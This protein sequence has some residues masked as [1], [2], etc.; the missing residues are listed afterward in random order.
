VITTFDRILSYLKL[1]TGILMIGIG[2]LLIL[3]CKHFKG[4]LSIWLLL[5]ICGFV[6]LFIGYK[7]FKHCNSHIDRKIENEKKQ[8]I[9]YLKEKGILKKL[10]FKD[11]VIGRRSE[12]IEVDAQPA[13][14]S[15]SMDELMGF[16]RSRKPICLEYSI[17]Y[18]KEIKDGET[19]S[20]ISPEIKK[21]HETLS[22]LVEKQQYINLYV[23]KEDVENY[24]FDLSFLK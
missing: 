1:S 5:L 9:I 19:I 21:D 14:R 24:F 17:L 18:Y 2:I 3:F 12:I 10:Y 15:E 8:N 23:D 16:D 11:I 13:S 4:L 22:F 7:L 6:F 20:F